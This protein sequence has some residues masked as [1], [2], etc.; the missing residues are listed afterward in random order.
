[1]LQF[2][3]IFA[4]YLI[5]ISGKSIIST[6]HTALAIMLLTFNIGLIYAFRNYKDEVLTTSKIEQME[7]EDLKGMKGYLTILKDK[8]AA[9]LLFLGIYL[10]LVKKL[11]DVA[12][13]LWAE[14]GVSENGLGYDKTTL[15]TYSTVGGMLSVVLYLYLAKEQISEMPK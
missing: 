15:G 6:Y 11:V 2:A 1:M 5:K 8:S 12:L 7:S 3:P 9:S 14:I 10:R 4:G 13:H